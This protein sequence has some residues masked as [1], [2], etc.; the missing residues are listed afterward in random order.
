[1][2]DVLQAMGRAIEPGMTTR[3]LDDLGRVMLERE[4]AQSA[5]ELCYEFPGANLHQRQ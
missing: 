2:A 3:E 1:M 4:G 5:P